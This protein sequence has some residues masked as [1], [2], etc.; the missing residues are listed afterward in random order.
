M[1][2]N[3]KELL[4]MREAEI[5]DFKDKK[6]AI[7]SFNILYQ[8]ITTIRQRDG[9]LL[10]DSQGNVTSH[11]TG[12]FSRT[13]KLMKEGIRPA[14][15]FDGKAPELKKQEREKRRTAKEEAQRSFE[16][17]EAAGKIEE[18]KKYAART[19]RL[20]HEM[21]EESKELIRALGLPVIQAPSE[22]E[23]QVAHIV[24]RGDAFGGVSE[25]YDSLLYGVRNLVKNLTISGKRKIGASYVTVKPKL[26]NISENLNNLG[27]DQDQLIILAILVGTDY[28]PGGI[29]GIGPKTA[30]KLVRQHGQDFDNVFEEAGWD[31]NSDILWEEIYHLIKNMKVKDDYLMR[32]NSVDR[33]KLHEILVEKHDFSEER[34]ENSINGLIKAEEEKEQ[35]GLGE[36]F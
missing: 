5:K 34:V 9:T 30:L 14:F 24:N 33:D 13:T 22:G 15:V 36:W 31:K 8:F 7:D 16:K 26:I 29:R 23:A 21:V 19:S 18:M 27:I 4:M 2:T 32:W 6:L 12:L 20:T 25:D 3:L 17:A 1:G 28:N 35:K 10:K 11:L